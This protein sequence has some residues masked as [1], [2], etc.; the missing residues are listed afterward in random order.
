MLPVIMDDM[1]RQS[2]PA[3]V[4]DRYSTFA[5]ADPPFHVSSPIYILFGTHVFPS[6]LDGRKVTV[7][8]L[9]PSVF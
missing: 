4:K 5:L 7:N 2:L 9:F 1:P 8:D 3:T 6:I